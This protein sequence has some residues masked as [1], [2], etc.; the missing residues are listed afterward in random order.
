MSTKMD[1]KKL[2]QFAKA[3]AKGKPKKGMTSSGEK[4]IHIGKKGAR[5]EALDISP[6]KMGK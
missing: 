6:M 5:E 3:K 2:A 4:G 1:L